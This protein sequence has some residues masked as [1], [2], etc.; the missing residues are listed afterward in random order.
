M[1]PLA[2]AAIILRVPTPLEGGWGPKSL[3]LLLLLRK[4]ML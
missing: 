1:T 3:G 4:A 2:T